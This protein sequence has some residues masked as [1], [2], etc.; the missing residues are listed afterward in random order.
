MVVC[1]SCNSSRIRNDYKPAPLWLRLIGIR[2][3]LCDHCNR[4]FKAFCPISPKRTLKS[5]KSRRDQRSNEISKLAPR[6]DLGQLRQNVADAQLRQADSIDRMRLSLEPNES[7]EVV[8][9]QEL[10]VH[11]DLKTQVLKL[12]LQ[13]AQGTKDAA[14]DRAGQ[15]NPN[16]AL[17]CSECASHNVKRRHRTAIERAALALTDHK[18]FSCRDCGA[19]FYAKSDEPHEKDHGINVADAGMLSGL[20]TDGKG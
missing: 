7:G 10:P 14:S 9:G 13:G 20:S 1:P 15:A 6:V 5:G 17:Q 8:T 11:Y 16:S 2:A 4:Q 18:A 19:S 12:H 3:L